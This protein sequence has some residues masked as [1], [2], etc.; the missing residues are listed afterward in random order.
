M[1][2]GSDH[3][4]APRPPG[5]TPRW[6]AIDALQRCFAL[7]ASTTIRVLP[8]RSRLPGYDGELPYAESALETPLIASAEL[9]SRNPQR[10]RLPLGWSPPV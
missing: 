10:R 3:S 6:R 9:T 2:A 1:A 7:S 4:S 8:G 5:R